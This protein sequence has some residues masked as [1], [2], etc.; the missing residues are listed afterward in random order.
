MRDEFIQLARKKDRTPEEETE[1][2]GMKR[3]MADRLMASKA[4]DIYDAKV[5]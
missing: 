3:E 4:E 1:L 5:L 2:A